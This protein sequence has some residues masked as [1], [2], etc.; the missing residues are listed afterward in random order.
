M[1][2]PGCVSDECLTGKPMEMQI[3]KNTTSK[4]QFLYRKDRFLTK[5]LTLFFPMFPFDPPENNRKPLV[6]CCFQGDQKGILGKKGLRRI[7][8]NA[9]FQP[10]LAQT[11]EAWYLNLSN[12]YRKKFRFYKTSGYASFYN[13]ITD[14]TSELNI[15]TILTDFQQTKNSSNV[16]PQAFLNCS[17]K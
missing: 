17:L 3:C 8:C 4:L 1:T 11:Y 16:F 14:S 12:K 15:S 7:L 10:H 13:W 2:Y 5:D 6:F 9:L